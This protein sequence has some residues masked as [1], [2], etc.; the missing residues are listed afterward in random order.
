LVSVSPDGK[1]RK[2]HYSIPLDERA[3]FYG[4]ID[5]YE[6]YGLF[7]NQQYIILCNHWELVVIERASGQARK[8][9]HSAHALA[10]L[11]LLDD[12]I[13]ILGNGIF[14]SMDCKGEKRKIHFSQQRIDK[15]NDLD[16]GGKA[17]DLTIL[18]NGRLLFK[19]AHKLPKSAYS[20][21]E[22]WL[23]D[24]GTDCLRRVLELP[25]QKNYSL[26][27]VKDIPYLVAAE[28]QHSV[29]YRLDSADWHLQVIARPP[30][31]DKWNSA[32]HHLNGSDTNGPIAYPY[33]LADNFLC[34]GGLYPACINLSE[35]EKSPLLWLPASKAV[36]KLADK[37]LFLRHNYWFT[38]QSK[39][40]N[41][42]K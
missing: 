23:Y 2:L 30:A 14:E 13:Y 25:T 11:T 39:K 42:S 19:V 41:T 27:S 3:V 8:F 18:G 10:G 36:F 20:K 33:I 16:R 15:L 28:K 31:K 12:R 26:T 35:P 40:N 29:I 7:C 37:I 1:M 24:S 6:R 32:V 4:E 21:E 17:H 5:C 38:V 34:C 22:I 9:Q